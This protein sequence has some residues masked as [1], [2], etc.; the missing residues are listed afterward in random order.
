MGVD[1]VDWGTILT[2]AIRHFSVTPYITICLSTETYFELNFRG[3]MSAV[4]G[5]YIFRLLLNMPRHDGIS[6]VCKCKKTCTRKYIFHILKCNQ[7]SF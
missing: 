4:T 1:G 5:I 7:I 6:P 2:P 3:A